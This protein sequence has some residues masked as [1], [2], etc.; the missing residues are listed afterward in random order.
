MGKVKALE[1]EAK[2]HGKIIDGWT[3][4]SLINHGKSAAVFLASKEQEK[5]AVKVFDDELIEKYGDKT[6]LAR[7]DRELTLVGQ[8][9]PN[10]VKLFSGGV[11]ATT[12]TILLHF[13][14][15]LAIKHHFVG[16]PCV[17]RCLQSQVSGTAAA[18][19]KQ[20]GRNATN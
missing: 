7:I 6:Q 1:L 5:A 15:I 12:G 4:E 11:D 14:F 19:L 2:L 20:T 9:H 16:V 3:I 8:I 13:S 18:L 10:M 17:R